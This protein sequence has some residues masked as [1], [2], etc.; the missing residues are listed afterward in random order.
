M[1][2][3]AGLLLFLLPLAA[4]VTQGEPVATHV[5]IL[6]IAQRG[7]SSDLPEHTLEAYSLAI[8]QGADY[9]EPDLVMTR[10]GVFV[11]R[12]ENEISETTDVADRPE[13]ADRRTTKT[14]GGL[15]IT[16][17]FT[18]DFTLAELRTLRARERLPQLRPESAEHDGRYAVPTLAEII[19]LVQRQNRAVGLVP[20]IKHPGYFASIGLPM[21][22]ALATQLADAGYDDD[23]D[24]AM[25]QS[26]EIAPLARL[27]ILTNLRLVQ[28][29]R[30]SGAP[31]DAPGTSY[32]HMTT[33]AG[34][35]AIAT[36][37][38]AIGPDKNW[39]IPR[40]ENDNLG[41]PTAVTA[42][43]QALGL[44]VIPYSFRPENYFLP[45]NMRNGEDPAANGLIEREIAEYLRIGI[46]GF[47]TDDSEEGVYARYI[48]ERPRIMRELAE[49]RV[50]EGESE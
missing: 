20:E 29:I 25:I 18:E 45:A 9:I 10:D 36:Y 23:D 5:D 44:R 14:I 13:F 6:V 38:D 2:W 37:A 31:A 41:E 35:R 39:L 27:D 12:H 8:D 24:P 43:A 42:N 19:A 46:D 1:R 48:F 47:F 16:G 32:A 33:P 28:L 17:W 4:C 50:R 40:D 30:R 3:R 26:F 11:S 34:L 7:A 49:E 22:E 15:E 21:E